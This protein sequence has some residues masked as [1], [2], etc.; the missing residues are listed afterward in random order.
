MANKEYQPLDNRDCGHY[1]SSPEEI[2]APRRE[3]FEREQ[4]LLDC[5]LSLSLNYCCLVI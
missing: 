5:F 4:E 1:P 2:E 3:E